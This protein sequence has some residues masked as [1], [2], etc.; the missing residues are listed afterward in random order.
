MRVIATNSVGDGPPSDE[1][2]GT[3]TA[4]PPRPGAV[5]GL[6]VTEGDAQLALSW[7]AVSGATGYKVQ[8]KSGTETFADAAADA[9]QH[10][11]SSG[12]TTARTIT[13]LANGT[14]YTVRV[15]ATNS[16]GDGPPSDEKTGTPTAPPPRPG[17]VTG[18]SVTEGDAQLALS[19]SAVSGATGY[20]VQWKSG[21]ETFADAAA[22]ARQHVISSG[23]TTARTITGLANGT[24][25]TV[26]V[27]A[28]NSVG[29]GPPSDEKTGTPTAPPPRPG[30][31]TGLSVTEG[32]A[33]LALSW[34]AVSGAT[35]YKVQWKSGTET[36]ADAA[37]DA[38]QHVISSGTTT[39]RTITG[40]ANGTPYTVRVIATN[41]VGDG[42]PSDEK[43]GTPTAPPPR[44][45]AV[46]GL[47]VT[48][49]D[50][51]LALS[52]SA[53]SGATGYKVQWKSGTETFADAA[54]DARQHVISSGTTTAR[55]ITGL[56]NGT[57]YTVRVIATNSVGDGPPSDEKT[58]TPTAP[59]PRPGAVTGLSV[60]EGDAQLALSWSAVS[61]ATGYK[62]QWKS[63]TETF[64]DAAAD[65]RQH[66]ISSGTTTARTITGLANGTP[67]T[68]RVIATNSVGDGPPSDEKTGTPTAPPPRPGAVT[69]LSVTEG[70]AQLALSWSAVSGA[71]GYKVQWKSGTETFADA[72][73]DARQH[74]ISS[75]TTTA[76]TITGLANGTPYTVRVIATNSVGD[77][78]PSDEKT[79]TPT[80]PP[81]RPGAV[82]GLSV[83]EGDAQLALSWSAV[84]GATGYKVQWKSGTE[85]FADAAADARQHVISS[86]TTTARTIT[87]LANGTPYTVRVIATNSVGD[88]PPSDE[89]TG[90]PTAPPPRPG[91]VTGLSV[92]E[93]DAQLALSWS[94]VS[95]ATGYK[96]QWK[97]GTETFADAAADARQHVISSGTTTAR[98]ITGLANGTPYTVRVIATNSVGDGPPSDEKTGTPTA[99][100][101]RP[102]AVTGLSVTEGDAQLAL[103]WSAVSGATGYK[104]QWK[105][106]TETFADA[107]AD[108]RQHVISSGTTT[109]RTITGLANGTPYTVRVI[110][111]NS[112]GDGPPS[113][114]KT[115]TPTAPPPRPGAVTGLSVTEGDA[116]LALSWSAVSG[117]TGYKVQW[118]SGTETFADAAA[119]ARQHVISSG[120]T[121]A[122]TITGLANGTPYTVRVIATNSVGDGPPSDEKTGTP[123]APPPRPG[124]VTGL[125]VTEGDAQLALSWSAVSGATGYKVQW[126]SGTETF[127][128]AA[129]D[130][131]Q[132]VISSGTTTARTITG[133]ANGT[134]YTVRVIATNSVGDGPPSDEKTG[135]PTAPPPRPGAVTGLSVTEGDAQL[136][137]SWSAVSGATGYKV[138][139][140]S[141]TETFADAAADA[142]QHVISSG[143]TTART[144]T[145]LANG[146]PY[147]V[148]VIATNSVGDGPPSD[149][150]TGT[151]TAPPPRPGAVTGLSVTEGDAQLALSW[152]AVSGATGYKVQWK[153]GTETFA[154]AAAD[155]RQHVI[156]SGTTTAR[157]ITG[158]ANGTPY[159]V[160]VIATNS[161]G[162]GPPSDEKTGT[163]TA[164]PPRPG[165]VTGLSVTEGD[166]QL[167]LSWSAVSGATGYKVQWKSGT[168][169]FA[170][171]AADARQH[172]ISS[173]TTTARTITGLA[174]GTPYTVRVIATNSVG[175]GPPSDE[176]TGTPTAPPPRPGAVTGLSVTEGDAQLALSWSA[177]SGATGYK[178]QWK[179]GTETFADAAADARQHVISSGTTTARTITGLANG[180]PYTVRVIAT[181]SVGDGPPSDEKTGT[182]TAPPPR[183]GAVTGLSV[184]EGDAQLA[185]SWSAVSGA[186]GYKVQWKSGT[187]TFADAAA[188]A[189]QHVISSG[190]TTARTITGLANGTPYTVRVIATNSVG[191]GPPSDE[192]TGTPTAPPPRPG[193]VTGL[194]VTEGDAQL[195]LS[196]SA[197]SGATGYKV[198]WKSGTETFADAAADARQHVISSGTTTARTITGLA[199]GTPYTVRVIATNSVGD[200]PPSDEKTG[201][202]TAPPPRPGAVTGL[203]V[204]EGDAQLALS[205]S[206]V[207]GATG[208]KVQWKSGTETFADAAA[209][210]RQHVISSGTTTARTITGLANG[211]PYTVR[212]IATNSVGDGPPSDEKTGTPT[213][214][215]PRPGAVTGLSVTEGDAQLALSWSAVSGA[216]GY[217]VQWKSGTETFADAAADARQHVISSGTTTARTI[218]G[219]ANGTPYTVRVIATN[220]VGDGPPSDEKTGTPTAP[221]PRPG[222]VT[223]LSVTEG[224]AQLALSWSA[225]SGATGYKV[226]W[227]S[228]TETFADAAA[229]ARQHVISSG[230]TTA[231]TITGLANGTP[232]TV[233]VIATNSVGDGPPSDE[234]TGTPTAPPPRPGAVTGLSVTEG[235][236]Q[237]ALSWSA[238]S[239]ATGY[240]VQWKSGT[241]TFADAAADARQHVIS[242][243][244]TTART[245]TG[246]ANGTPYTVRVI[247]T[248]S[249]GDGPPSDEKTGTPTAP[250][251]RPGA[252]TGLSVTE[253]DAQLA[254]SW[255]AVSGATGY[256]VQWK[257]GTETFADAAADARQHVISSGTTTA[258][259]ITGLA[260]GTPYTV[261]VIATNSVGDGPPSD[262]KTGTP[263]APPPRPGAVTGLSVTEGDAQLALSWSAVSGATGYKV[264]WKSGTETFA[265]AAADARQ[266]VISSGTTTARTITGLANGTP[267]TVRVIATNSVGDGPPSDEKTGTP[268]APPPRPGAVTG[269]SVTEGDAQ[270]ALSWSAVSGATGYKVQWKSGT[271]TFA[272]AAADARQH[273]ISS[274]T[275]TARTITGL[276]NG[277]PYTVRVIA[278][279]SV[280]DG[281]PS[282][283]KTGTPTAP[284]PRPGAVTGLSVTEGDAQLAL[285][286]SAVSGATGYKVQWKSG[287]E[288]F[289]DA[290]A[291]ARQH[292]ISSGTT[293]ARAPGQGQLRIALRHRQSG[294]R[295]RPGRRRRRRAGLLVR[296]G[297]VAHRVGRDHPHR[298]RR[299]V[300]QTG[301]GAGG[302][303]PARDHMLAR[304]RRGVREGLRT[305][306]P[307]HLVARGPA[308]RAP[309]QGQLRIALRHRQS[310]HRSRPGRRRRRRAG[311]LVRRGAVAHRVGRDHPHRIRCS[312]GQTGDG[313]GGRRPARDH[314]LARVRRG[315]REGLRTRLPL[316]LVARG[317]AHRAPGQ[318]QLS[319]ALRHRQSGHRSRPGQRVGVHD[320]HD[321]RL[322]REVHIVPYYVRARQLERKGFI[323]FLQRVVEDR[324]CL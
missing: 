254:L 225:V 130:A 293:T 141:G 2:T 125:S 195:A 190:T 269:L 170:D 248:N 115:G 224:D 87:G 227:K 177:V 239:G 311:L 16:V 316:H 228:G 280:G 201:T 21:T 247:A 295:S 253:G 7:S 243:G 237:L 23:T 139:W 42:P 284:P 235:D 322:Q 24:P 73:A 134:P 81:P 317:P 118:K 244:T 305:R 71:T 171:A 266:H 173:G 209:D 35:G 127:A 208:Y 150:K 236:A 148:R 292:V 260:N 96:V 33:Q 310:G 182:P 13:G 188:D 143:T 277:T 309:G 51:Q 257:S 169:T 100:P 122:R 128:D 189:R 85:T 107:A 34:S 303:R 291:D 46:T 159:T 155:A 156:S 138:Q 191:D 315:V 178:V 15:I 184:T 165:A 199:N 320:S 123:T 153:S 294:H 17:A 106:G 20:K 78:P 68:V 273:V 14:P 196:W 281:P 276:A 112:V 101:P 221:P 149:E 301:D 58:G 146:T 36:F 168:E 70:D 282:D 27:I 3:P 135:T 270:L 296:R 172:V 53:V 131:R 93:G 314:M 38:R 193:A 12:T 157:T 232:Y 57:P 179:S 49:G 162:D 133:L 48:E 175:D 308:H 47:S 121:T 77:G 82:T 54:A 206:A 86:G 302:R 102:G 223:G 105:S 192:K 180:T 214:P 26:R 129:A 120:T 216:T 198:Q 185:L 142:R 262:E 69:G 99:P 287:T 256:K 151:P 207:S 92:T 258:R 167:A 186:T 166:A 313:A 90:T 220:S 274:G 9:R 211:T 200:G 197:V 39:A 215:P 210:A 324:H 158:L 8:W 213:A 136:A 66:V 261:R 114:E 11:I 299:S 75:G 4:P 264:Q 160:R 117:A 126:K 41:S 272:D 43:T 286:W 319:I 161:V 218:T 113:D 116:Q 279:N 50:A 6:S 263:T 84:S 91:A 204:T 30:A 268:T 255:S 321:E 10:V 111:T 229:D 145:G 285:S 18:L 65:A 28:T 19:W 5:T 110:A 98:T 246:L 231:R 55:T 63:G 176:K 238:V 222:A 163:P 1:K 44:P 164:P 187:E 323:V 137:L 25:Y 194:S 103:S 22:D 283:E 265:D 219:L 104:V 29:D 154:D 108:A 62:V 56:A 304:V 76:R 289:A 259:T 79:G 45:G 212:V 32:D 88:G 152:S 250:P 271:E 217:K 37:A 240:K 59:P 140:K 307:L 241:E 252:V 95:G 64:A 174:N 300:G 230:T 306:L 275:T 183:P 288:T 267:Y 31:V 245:I 74:V 226:Q 290:A 132:H 94:A 124:A 242:S 312:V 97:S 234:K 40:L 60:T 249:V 297:A 205:W 72:A 147:T 52:W 318:G 89:K 144:I 83:T 251:P 61:G 233:R 181:N 67:Y 109:A 202:P 278:T 298:V 80:A 119:D 203:S